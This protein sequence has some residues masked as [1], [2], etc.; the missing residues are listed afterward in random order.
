MAHGDQCPV[1]GTDH[2]EQTPLQIG[3]IARTMQLAILVHHE[4][5]FTCANDI[6]QEEW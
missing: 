5:T 6:A 2:G 3:H 1:I 4:E